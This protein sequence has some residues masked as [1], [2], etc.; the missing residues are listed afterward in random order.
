MTGPTDSAV[1]VTATAR[2]RLA[3]GT[4]AEVS[5]FTGSH[6]HVPG[7][8]LRG[9]LAAAWIAEHGTPT[10]GGAQQAEFR[11]LFD[12]DIRYGPL[13]PD[14]SQ[15]VPLSVLRCKYPID[16]GCRAVAVDRAFRA[17]D[18]SDRCPSCGW[19]LTRGKGGLAGAPR[20]ERSMRTSIKPGSGRVVDGELYAHAALPAGTVLTGTVHG[21]HGWLESQR[22]VWLGGRRTVGGEAALTWTP[23]PDRPVPA[24]TAAGGDALVVRLLS[25]AVFVDP[26]G[27]PRPD[28]D[29]SLDLCGATVA[30]AWT[31]PVEWSGWHAASRLPK[32]TDLVA[33]TGSTYR[34]TG[35]RDVLDELADRIHRHGW[36]LR[37]AEGFGVA[38][39]ATGPWRPATSAPREATPAPD[40]ATLAPR[41]GAEP[42]QRTGETR[43]A[44]PLRALTRLG[45]AGY[46]QRWLVNTMRSLQV[47]QQRGA[48]DMVTEKIVDELLLQATAIRLTG[49]QREGIRRTL[50]GLRERDLRDLTTLYLATPEAGPDRDEGGPDRQADLDLQEST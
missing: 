12:G 21:R 27:R 16:D 4:A 29:P 36:G 20:M 50:L 7:S 23:I 18:D 32:P 10:R 26:A 43:L 41:D 42:T 11:A 3:L 49:R 33:A 17:F 19:L 40:E 13:L 30:R 14:G 28:P 46:Q 48:L 39:V 37:R 2:Q 8:V 47:E 15:M 31:R 44:Q 35:P 1:Q 9:A 34:I 24:W 6:D 22:T 45:L 38:E 5:Y 25:P